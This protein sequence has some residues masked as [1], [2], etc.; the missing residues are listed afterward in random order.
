MRKLMLPD[1]FPLAGMITDVADGD[2]MHDEGDERYLRVALSALHVIDSALSD[3]PPPRHILDLPSGHGRVTR[4][5]RARFPDAAITVCD[6][7]RDGVAFA[8]ERFRARGVCSLDDFRLL[9]LGEAFDL[10]WVGSLITHFPELQTR[11]FLDCMV[12]HM[13]SRSTLVI[14]SH[15]AYVAKRM[16]G[17]PYGL[18][19]QAARAVLKEYRD[20]GYGYRDYPGA[21]GYGISL[22][23]PRWYEHTLAGSP[24][25]LIRHLASGWDDHHDVLVLRLAAKA[26][27]VSEPGRGFARLF[28]IGR[29]DPAPAGTGWFEANYREGSAGPGAVPQA[30]EFDEAWYVSAYS[31]V[32]AAIERGIFAS[33]LEHYRKFGWSEGRFASARQQEARS[34]EA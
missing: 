2:T 25:S 19:P 26:E 23:S 3:A 21:E 33:G 16:E 8:S 13:T 32:A 10:I 27:A 29:S 15:G 5:L 6:I 20:A 34:R 1:T 11:R 18:A 28:G 22:I 4:V 17:W 24:L 31:D 12:R 30:P 7:D 9:E 14:S